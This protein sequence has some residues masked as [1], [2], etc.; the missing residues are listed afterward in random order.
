MDRS[1]IP[2]FDKKAVIIGGGPAGLTA[3]YQ[4]VKEHY[5]PIVFEKLDKVGGIA[6]TEN[7]KGYYF[8][9][10]GHRFFTKAKE[11]N[12][13]WF[14]VLGDDFLLRPRLS[15][16]YYDHK[17]FAY[18]IKPFNALAGLGVFQ[19]TLITLS[20]LRSQLF[21]YRKEETFEQWVSNRFGKR[22]FSI[23]FKS[24]TEKVWGIS[25][26]ELKAEWAAQRIKGL[27]MKTA[28]LN[29]FVN[30]KGAIKSLIEE[31]HYPRRGPGMLWN[32]VK[33]RIE[34][35]NGHVYL[36]ST[37]CGVH[38]NG[39][40]IESVIVSH[41]GKEQE[42]AAN[43]FISSM[44]VTE[45][46]RKLTPPPPAEVLEAANHL[47]YRDFLTV[48]LIVNQ[49]HLF[50]DN[51][52]YVHDPDVQVGRI[53]NFKNWSPDM[54]PDSTKTSLGLEYFCNEG[55]ELWNAPDE[56]L[57]ELGKRELDRIGLAR[58]A[59]VIDGSVFRVE[60]AYPVYDSTYREHLGVIRNYID[61]LDNFQ[62][63][64]RN[65]LHRYNNQ[66][67]A[68]LTGMLAVRNL[69]YNEKNDLWI[70]NAEQE[71]HEE[72]REVDLSARE[73]EKV[74]QD[75]L[76]MAFRKLDPRAFGSALGVMSGLLL[77]F[78]TLI[79]V[80]NDLL[81]VAG[82]ML[83]LREYFPGYS[84]TFLGSFIGLFY[85]L[86]FGFLL[87]WG[88]AIIRNAVIIISMAIM[89]RRAELQLLKK[90]LDF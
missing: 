32:R 70:V 16:I 41:D 17:F 51:W 46:I 80:N 28:V 19:A 49:P 14:E 66:D 53:Q 74:Y 60:K 24:Y 30:Q 5:D 39:N 50:N 89:H 54:V 7:Y 48:C 79:V 31:F 88:F 8:D 87:G 37:V 64:G 61:T 42:F 9:M 47:S 18:P 44:P 82:K 2:D 57:I 33:E 58:Y 21:P 71:Y 52:I 62:T 15:R 73:V 10:G 40:R 11:V 38:R 83:L 75:V 65:G 55:D 43:Y 36:N 12:Q 3:A 27:S 4:L 76:S 78:A 86:L 77:C 72:I 81:S 69:L 22:L 34:E 45:F 67:H 29:M 84:I 25:T 90:I 6:R 59:D 68:M 23:F 35:K 85:G 1:D 63:I 56:E 13:F 20:Y 26:S